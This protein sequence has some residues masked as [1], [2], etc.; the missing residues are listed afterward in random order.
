MGCVWFSG[1]ILRQAWE[2]VG[3]AFEPELVPEDEPTLPGPELAA[4]AGSVA[5][6]A[7][8]AAAAAA[9]GATAFAEPASLR[10]RV[11]R[12]SAA[13]SSRELW[14]LRFLF[15]FLRYSADGESPAAPEFAWLLLRL[16][17][18]ITSVFKLIGLDRPCSFKKSPQALHKTAPCSLRRHSGV[19]SVWQFLHIGDP[20]PLPVPSAPLPFPRATTATL[21]FVIP[22]QLNLALLS[23]EL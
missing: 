1:K 11:S 6:D 8:P 9:T 5:D 12:V 19:V 16:R 22:S 7:E 4:G 2:I 13:C 14:V 10:I 21:D 20:V 23:A 17:D 15:S 3:F 18:F